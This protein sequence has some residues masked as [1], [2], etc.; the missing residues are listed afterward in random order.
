MRWLRRTASHSRDAVH[1]ARFLEAECARA[2]G[3]HQ[4]AFDLYV[5]SAQR[6]QREGYIH[7][8]ALV[9]E[10]QASL[11]L[12]TRRE[13]RAAVE[14]RQSMALYGEWGATA[15]VRELEL[16]LRAVESSAT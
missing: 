4:R 16:A 12:A 8:A 9:H 10:R 14:L 6:A 3:R 5:Q 2:A 1:M 15:K 11:L 13:T 7:H